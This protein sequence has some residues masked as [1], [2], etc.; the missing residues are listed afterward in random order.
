LQMVDLEPIKA[1]KT[2]LIVNV[3]FE[4]NKAVLL[5]EALAGLKNLVTFLKRNPV[6]TI[7]LEGHTDTTGEED[8]NLKLSLDRAQAVADFLLANEINADR[9]LIRGFGSDKPLESNDNEIGRAKN[10]RVE[11]RIVN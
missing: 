6:L 9:L 2:I 10:R 4:L 11:M 5:P 8:F 1:G 3:L 7:S